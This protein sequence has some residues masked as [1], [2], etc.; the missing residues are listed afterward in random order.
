GPRGPPAA[1]RGT[2]Y[3]RSRFAAMAVDVV[4]LPV[5]PDT[6]L[7]VRCW[8]GPGRPFLLVHGLASNAL[9]WDEVA[10]GLVAAGHPVYAVDLRSHGESSSPPGGYDTAT[11]AADVAAVADAL[12]ERAGGWPSGAV[13]AGQSWGGN[14]VVRLA[15]ERP[16]VVGALALLDG[17]WI[18]LAA[19]FDSWE[20]CAKVLR[21]PKLDG[22]R[23]GYLRASL[24]G[25]HRDWSPA[26]IEATLANLRVG[27]D[28][29]LSRRLAIPHHMAILRSMFDD[30]PHRFYPA[31]TMPALLM[32]AI[33]DA[34]PD[35]AA[36][37]RAQ[38]KAAAAA[39]PRATIREYVGADHDLHAQ[40]PD[41]VAADL[42]TLAAS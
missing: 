17:G 39:M 1:R 10:A 27:Q 2:S 21:P 3:L 20:A 30:P 8:A 16:D 15:A 22:V 18:D 12:R 37:V 36:R 28:G 7:S 9:L 25:Q 19:K 11:A 41:R 14:V 5:A 42:L 31:L 4:S 34:D 32:P 29:E 13:V 6:T 33:P 38:V 40:H 24:A 26:A 23:A 35:R